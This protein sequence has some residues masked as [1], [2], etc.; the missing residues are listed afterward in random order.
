MSRIA[1]SGKA[2]VV[3]LWTRFCSSFF[4]FATH[5]QLYWGLYFELAIPCHAFCFVQNILYNACSMNRGIVILLY[6]VIIWKMANNYRPYE[7]VNYFKYRLVNLSRAPWD[8]VPSEARDH[9]EWR[10]IG[11][12]TYLVHGSHDK[13]NSL[14]I[15]LYLKILL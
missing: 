6:E 1:S 14:C 10:V 12:P 4:I 9:I 5:S 7:V 3:M 11:L 2:T 13:L 8:L 15:Y